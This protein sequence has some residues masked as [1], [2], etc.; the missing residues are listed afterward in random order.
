MII[1]V[2]P[3]R[4]LCAHLQLH[5]YYI[6]ITFLCYISC[7]QDSRYRF[8]QIRS[9]GQNVMSV[10]SYLHKIRSYGHLRI[11]ENICGGICDTY[12][13]YLLYINAEAICIYVYT[14]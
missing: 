13:P 6:C 14:L 8:T 11:C 3:C 7:I 2:Y 9:Y 1:Y 10:R 4:H 5:M 12:C